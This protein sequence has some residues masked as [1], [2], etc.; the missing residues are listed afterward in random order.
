MKLEDINKA[1]EELLIKYLDPA[2]IG[3]NDEKNE[4]SDSE[5]MPVVI[6]VSDSSDKLKKLKALLG[7][8]YKGV[9][10]KDMD[11]AAKYVEK[12]RKQ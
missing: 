8:G 9:F 2:L 11:S 6:A 3:G 12:N 7:D 4:G 5:D 10:V 1:L